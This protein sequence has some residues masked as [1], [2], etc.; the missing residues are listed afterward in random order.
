MFTAENFYCD[1]VEFFIYYSEG[2]YHIDEKVYD[3][4]GNEE[5]KCIFEGTYE[6]CL[7]YKQKIKNSFEEER[8]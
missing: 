6:E 5:Y 2:Q 1:G 8:F 7:R 3:D 4:F